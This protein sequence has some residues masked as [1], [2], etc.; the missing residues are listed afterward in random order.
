MYKLVIFCFLIYLS[1]SLSSCDEEEKKYLVELRQTNEF[2]SF[3]IP[4]D[5]KCSSLCV[6]LFSDEG[7]D[8]MAYKN[9]LEQEILFYELASGNIINRIVFPKE[10]KNS[11]AGGFWGFH[12]VDLDNIYI[13]SLYQNI[14]YVS[15]SIGYIKKT[16]SFE[17]TDLGKKLIPFIPGM[18]GEIVFIDGKLYIPQ[19]VNPMLGDKMINESPVGAVIDTLLRNNYALPMTFPYLITQQDIGT[20]AGTGLNYYRCFDGERFVYSFYYSDVVYVADIN[21]RNIRECDIKSAYVDDVDV[22][23]QGLTDPNEVF[24][25]N[26]EH[27]RYGKI[28]YDKYRDVYYRI[29]YP[30]N[31]FDE[32]LSRIRK[33]NFSIIILDKE[34]NIIGE[35]LFPDNVFVPELLFIT[36]KGLYIST[37]NERNPDFDE[38]FLKFER[39]ELKEF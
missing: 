25:Y 34:L 21:H 11:I 31:D 26:V 12:V 28:Y 15:D 10:G 8:Y 1:L 35:T 22:P 4:D 5:V 24:K 2:C 16:I 14:I 37:N 9:E 29:V 33:K 36:D 18:Y 20:L 13:P 6:Q 23:N 38:D 27:S 7:K 19:T 3:E 32:N 39:I 30:A 17:K